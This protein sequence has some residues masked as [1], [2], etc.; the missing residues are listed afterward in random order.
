MQ[1]PAR[2]GCTGLCPGGLRIAPEKEQMGSDSWETARSGSSTAV[3][4]AASIPGVR[5]V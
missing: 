2:A 4:A 3:S 1:P 5:G